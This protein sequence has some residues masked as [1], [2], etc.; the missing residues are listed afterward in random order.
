MRMETKMIIN[1]YYQDQDKQIFKRFAKI[2]ERNLR[3]KETQREI[4]K[5]DQSIGGLGGYAAPLQ[6]TTNPFNSWG[7]YRKTC[8]I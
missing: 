1:N 5:Y 6:S 8:C 7:A 4:W 2:I 3:C